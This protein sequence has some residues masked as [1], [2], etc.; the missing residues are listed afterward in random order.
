MTPPRL[1]L[2]VTALALAAVAVTGCTNKDPDPGPPPNPPTTTTTTS[3]KPDPKSAAER[4]AVQRLKDFNAAENQLGQSG[5]ELDDIN[6]ITEFIT[7]DFTRT[8][9]SQLSWLS[10]QGAVQRGESTM[11]GIK[12]VDHHVVDDLFYDDQLTIEACNDTTSLDVLLPDGSSAIPPDRKGRFV[13]TITMWHW[14]D[15]DVW[16]IAGYITDGGRLC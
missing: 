4:A 12:V 14:A 10:S 2:A 13:V 8:Y 5:F 1:T 3:T 15:E 16:A 6:A 11:T 7:G 9:L